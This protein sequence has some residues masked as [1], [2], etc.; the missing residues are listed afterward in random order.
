M[1]IFYAIQA[2]G[3]GH[4]SRARELYPWLSKYGEVDFFLSGDNSNLDPGIPVTF[5]SKGLS[6]YYNN[7]GGLD[8][9][10]IAKAF[11]PLRL[12]KEIRDLPVEKYDLVINDFDYITAAACARKKIPSIGWSHQASFQSELTPRPARRKWIGESILKKYAPATSYVGLHFKKYDDFIFT[13]VIK[14]EIREAEPQNLGHITVYLP[15]WPEWL[16]LLVFRAIKHVPFQIFSREARMVKHFGHITI[17]PIQPEMFN[18]SFIT[19]QGI[20]TGGG[21]ETPAE[22]MHMGKKIIAVPIPGQY[23]QACNAAALREWN[24]P[25]ASFRNTG[26]TVSLEAWLNNPSP[27]PANFPCAI[28]DCIDYILSLHPKRKDVSDHPI[29]ALFS[30]SQLIKDLTVN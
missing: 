3:N 21:F 4:I 6:L 8:Y 16:L 25:I 26:L 9:F 23:E 20:I 29:P 14:K 10:K 19:C 5:R 24:I 7:T 11:Q 18:K 13:P 15:A 2:T 28:Q 1:K 12:R 30:P 17:Y 22:A 27:I